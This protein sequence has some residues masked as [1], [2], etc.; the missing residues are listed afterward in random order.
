[1]FKESQ[2]LISGYV[3]MIESS[4]I[5]W[6]FKQQNVVA[7][8]SCEAEYLVCLHTG[9]REDAIASESININ[10]FVPL[11]TVLDVA[12]LQEQR[13]QQSFYRTNQD[14]DIISAAS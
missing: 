2:R 8:L 13:G 9:I 10:C 5:V 7:L 14:H 4:P 11:N 12:R 6:S 3:V 1:M